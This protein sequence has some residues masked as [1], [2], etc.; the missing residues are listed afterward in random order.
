MSDRVTALVLIVV[1]A[2]F[3]VMAFR[4]QPGFFNDPL[5]PRFVPIAIGVF[6][7][8][9]SLA[10]LIKPRS[11]ANWPDATTGGRLVLCLVAFVAY[12]LLLNPLGF[13][14]STTLAFA[15]FAMLFRGRPLP[16][17]LAGVVFSVAS[18]LLFSTA[19]DL[20]LPTGRIFQGWF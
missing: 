9:V 6:L 17:L 4:I 13:I 12:A 15:G 11:A 20:F 18:Y 19:L 2:I 3:V 16:A 14:V 7:A 10:L 1:S 8:G 5:G